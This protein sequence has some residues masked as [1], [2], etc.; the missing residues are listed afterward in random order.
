MRPFL[1]LSLIAFIL[2]INFLPDIARY[3][4]VLLSRDVTDFFVYE[5]AV[6]L[7]LYYFV[8]PLIGSLLILWAVFF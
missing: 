4:A 6:N 7:V 5:I 1:L 8:V 2:T 3:L